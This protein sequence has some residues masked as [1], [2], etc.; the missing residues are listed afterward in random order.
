METGS[1]RISLE[2]VFKY[3]VELISFAGGAKQVLNMRNFQ[4]ANQNQICKY[5][6]GSEGISVKD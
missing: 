2:Y 4:Y 1:G 5:S 6:K 3:A